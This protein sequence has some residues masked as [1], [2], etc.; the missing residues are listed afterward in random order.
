MNRKSE[1]M[2]KII[3]LRNESGELTQKELAKALEVTQASIS[4]WEQNQLSISGRN[5]IK[6]ARF[7]NV[8]VDSLLGI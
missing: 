1:T 2:K 5:L 7:F 4:R 3:D 8:S 6:V